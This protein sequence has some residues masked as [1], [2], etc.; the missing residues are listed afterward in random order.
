MRAMTCDGPPSEVSIKA[1]LDPDPRA[2]NGAEL[3]RQLSPLPGFTARV[4]TVPR[5][6]LADPATPSASSG[7]RPERHPPQPHG[8]GGVATIVH[9]LASWCGNDHPQER[10]GAGPRQRTV[11]DLTA[12]LGTNLD[13]LTTHPAAA[14][15]TDESRGAHRSESPRGH[16]LRPPI[17]RRP[18]CVRTRPGCGRAMR[19][20]IGTASDAPMNQVE[21]DA[22]HVWRPHQ[23]LLLS[24]DIEH[25]RRR[26]PRAPGRTA[27]GADLGV[28]RVPDVPAHPATPSWP[29]WRPGFR[30]Q[31][32]GSGEP[33]Q[34]HA[35]PAGRVGPRTCTW[36]SRMSPRAARPARTRRLRIA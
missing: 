12:Y 27:A 16:P 36:P 2:R 4:R 18:R 21:C 32:S 25:A 23:W 20:M 24:G 14:D 19:A 9:V 15:F 34:A 13:S 17:R 8:R 6:E 30:R 10:G 1:A 5:G 35:L 31:Q 26:L 22:G 11:E 33:A 28:K 3:A 29:R 7:W